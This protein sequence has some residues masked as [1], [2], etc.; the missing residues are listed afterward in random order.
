MKPETCIDCAAPAPD[1]DTSYTAIGHGWRV[2][3]RP[4][5]GGTVH[6]WRCGPCW[7]KKRSEES[8]HF[9][10]APVRAPVAGTGTSTR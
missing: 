2:H 8:G 4:S 5:D 7:K 10:C 9:V 1:A 6:E 3:A